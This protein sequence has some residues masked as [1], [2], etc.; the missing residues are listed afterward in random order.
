MAYIELKNV[1]K[2]YENSEVKIKAI[3]NINLEIKEG[4]I[5][6]V[7]GDFCAGK[8][9]LINLLSTKDRNFDGSILVN[10]L[11]TNN[12]RGTNLTDYR[13]KYISCVFDDYVLMDNLTI[14]EN[15]EMMMS[16]NKNKTDVLSIIKKVGLTKKVDEFPTNV[17]KKE[18]KL[19]CIACALAKNTKILLIDD[20]DY[21]LDNKSI[22]QVLRALQVKNKK[23]KTTILISTN[24]NNIAPIAN[25]VITL[26][27]GAIKNIK[28]NKKIKSV[29][30]LSW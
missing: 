26:E 20:L 15:V 17:T 4:E 12:L 22:K 11:E 6:I 14:K 16:L 29:G 3:K 8:T 19:V 10:D 5:I 18:R 21:L 24:K 9:T 28:I 30:D 27:N 13:R 2:T 25:K 7:N 1:N 23:D